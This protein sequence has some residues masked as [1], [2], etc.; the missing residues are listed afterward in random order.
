MV[1]P[2]AFNA[3][4]VPAHILALGTVMVGFGISTTLKL[5]TFEQ[6]PT[7]PITVPV[8]IGAFGMAV[9]T[10]KAPE[11]VEAFKPLKPV[12]V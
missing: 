10:T 1:A 11:V 6:V 8:P 9:P 5:A 4:L 2:L 3:T 12:Q 7:K